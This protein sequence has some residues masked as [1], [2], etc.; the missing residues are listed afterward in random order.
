[1]P[2]IILQK[3]AKDFIKSLSDKVRKKVAYTILK[4]QNGERNNEIFKKLND[5]I[6]EIRVTYEGLR[7]RLFSFWDTEEGTL[8]VSTHGIIKKTQKT[9]KKEIKKAENL[10]QEYFRQ[11]KE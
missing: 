7:Y 9:P 8:I 2:Q 1:M 3:E 5:N 11:K 4:I 6:W 10:R